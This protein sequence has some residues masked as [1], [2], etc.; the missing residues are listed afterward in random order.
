MQ[1]F[2]IDGSKILTW[3]A[4]HDQFTEIMAF[5]YYYGRNMNAWIDC[6]DELSTEPT[7]IEIQYAKTLEAKAPD[8]LHEIL[9]C[10][11]FVNFRK[12]EQGEPSTLMLS[13]DDL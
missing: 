11:A 13:M 5:P 6:V 8:I 1:H 12:I 4:F 3:V 2:I 10:A 7:L 9:K